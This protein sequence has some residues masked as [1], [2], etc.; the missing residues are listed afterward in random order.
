MQRL[1]TFLKTHV[2][3]NSLELAMVTL[4]PQRRTF[5]RGQII[6]EAEAVHRH[7]L[8][9]ETGLARG[10]VLEQSGRD[11]TWHF[12]FNDEHS[13]MTNLFVIDYHS[14]NTEE[15]SQIQFEAVTDCEL[16][17][18]PFDDVARL[19][20]LSKKWVGFSLLM[21]NLAYS[22]VHRKYFTMLTGDAEERYQRLL[23]EMPHLFDLFPH[24]QIASYIGITPQHLSRIRKAHESM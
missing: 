2:D 13:H 7:I 10:Y 24:Y 18:I 9:L 1:Q 12:Y 6:L 4:T 11:R 3:L 21:A 23:A 19:H 20:R 14:L 17:A 16:Y 15:P 22:F 5:G 8:F